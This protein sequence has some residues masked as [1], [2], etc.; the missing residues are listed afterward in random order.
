VNRA[1]F[2]TIHITNQKKI[3]P[4]KSD[5]AINLVMIVSKRVLLYKMFLGRFNFIK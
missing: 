3:H 1:M 2:C 5:I 4:E